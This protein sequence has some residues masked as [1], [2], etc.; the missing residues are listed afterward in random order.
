MSCVDEGK[1]SIEVDGRTFY[2]THMFDHDTNTAWDDED[3][4]GFRRKAVRDRNGESSG[5]PL[6]STELDLLEQSRRF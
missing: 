5:L 3:G 4:H 2:V 1:G 6:V